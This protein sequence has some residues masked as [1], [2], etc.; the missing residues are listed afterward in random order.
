VQAVSK[1]PLIDEILSCSPDREL[2]AT[3]VFDPERDLFLKD[4]TIGRQVSKTDPSLTALPVMPLT[5]SMEM[6]AEAASLL[7]ENEVVIGMKG[8]RGHRWVL[9]DAPP[10]TL[11]AV[12][13]REPG[14]HEVR[15]GIFASEQDPSSGAVPFTEGTVLF[16]SDYPEPPGVSGF[17]LRNERPSRWTPDQLYAEKMFH[18]PRWQGVSSVDR[19]GEDGSV[20]TLKVLPWDDFFSPPRCGGFLTDPVVLDA[21]GQIVGFWTME[22]LEE[23]F[24]V[25]PYRFEALYLYRPQQGVGRK[26]TCLA[27]TGL[28]GSQRVFSDFDLIGEDGKPWMRLEAWEDKRFGLP[29]RAYSFLL[30]PIEVIPSESWKEPFASF[31]ESTSLCCL[32]LDA[33]YRGDEEFW[34][35][36]FAHLILNRNERAEFRGLN[37]SEKRSAHWLLERLL[38]KDAVRTYLKR[39][40][41]LTIGPTDVEI[42][43]DA[44]GRILPD[45]DW[46]RDVDS[47]PLLSLAHTDGLMVAVAG[48]P[49]GNLS[50]GIDIGQIRALED[51]VENTAFL[52]EERALL[53]SNNGSSQEEW[54]VRSLSAKEAAARALGRGCMEHPASLVVQEVNPSAG[55]VKVALCGELLEAFPDLTNRPIRVRTLRKGKYIVASTVL[56]RSEHDR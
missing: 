10:V 44:F 14:S 45:G 8:F 13:R 17:S 1:L 18:G 7:V 52:P 40:Y 56:K 28:K 49:D 50:F 22:H 48:S 2:V 25:F 3:R 21:A 47:I 19:W 35:H 11:K 34:S 16:G 30:S 9:F 55:E 51:G 54:L 42:K 12:A 27:R 5:M 29:A 38:A 43:Q 6:M 23:G 37:L 4:H 41:G 33:L 20:A 36:V 39:R 15:V 53:C 31:Q 24:L 32:Q 26:V 46:A